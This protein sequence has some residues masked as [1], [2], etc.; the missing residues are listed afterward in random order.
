[1]KILH[2]ANMISPVEGIISQMQAEYNAS[3]VLGISYD[4]VIF[5]G[6]SSPEPC[7][8]SSIGHHSNPFLFKFAFLILKS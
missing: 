1:M 7:V 4:V 2:V 8:V 3:Q 6:F 5:A